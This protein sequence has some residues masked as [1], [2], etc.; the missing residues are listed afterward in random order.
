MY[1]C[2]ADS[3]KYLECL[4]INL[5]SFDL[6]QKWLY[7]DILCAFISFTRKYRRCIRILV[8]WPHK[9][10][11]SFVCSPRKTVYS[12]TLPSPFR[13]IHGWGAIA[14]PV[15]WAKSKE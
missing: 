8:P 9:I 1:I 6:K 15:N 11:V 5:G 10:T 12:E 13:A 14:S 7:L 3:F 4:E 2:Y